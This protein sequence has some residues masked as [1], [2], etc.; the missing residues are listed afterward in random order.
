VDHFESFFALG[1]RPNPSEI[2][3]TWDCG[4]YSSTGLAASQ[5]LETAL[6]RAFYR[7]LPDCR[8]PPDRTFATATFDTIVW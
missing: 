8:Q 6:N 5:R 7:I 3:G 2:P 1:H 4:S